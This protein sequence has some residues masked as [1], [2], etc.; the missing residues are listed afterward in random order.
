MQVLF[1]G[2]K[3]WPA[4]SGVNR[5][6]GTGSY[7]DLLIRGLRGHVRSIIVTQKS[8]HRR[9]FESDGFVDVYRVSSFGHRVF[10]LMIGNLLCAVK[11][12]FVMR[13]KQIDILHAHTGWAILYAHVLARLTRTPLIAT[14]HGDPYGYYD[15][16]FRQVLPY[17]FVKL[18]KLIAKYVFPKTDALVLFTHQD[19]SKVIAHTGVRFENVRLIP[20]GVEIPPSP[21]DLDRSSTALRVLY[22][23]RLTASKGVDA[24]LLSLKHLSLEDLTRVQV[25]I[26]G[27]G[28]DEG[29]L[30]QLCTKHKLDKFVTFHGFIEHRQIWRFY[31][32]ADVFLFPSMVE[33]FSLAL[34]E[35][36]SYGLACVVN[37][38]GHPFTDDEIMIIANNSP[39]TVAAA[40]TRLVRNPGLIAYYGS[41]ARQKV[42]S[43]YSHQLF[44]R[45]HLALYKE[46]THREVSHPVIVPQKIVPQ[47]V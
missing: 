32:A 17:T 2:I 23:G 20:T 6:G 10:R 38:Y 15:Y 28:E 47:S 13:Q 39:I 12:Y 11:A 9:A 41:R 42:E 46:H 19:H 36:M 35:A 14:P 34:L 30:R 4:N 40:V 7:C 1:L 31:R 24:L 45:R 25:D 29:M 21:R 16:S 8:K 3:E 5:A 33:G 37:D 18:V 44:V 22:V 26:V 43:E 27:S